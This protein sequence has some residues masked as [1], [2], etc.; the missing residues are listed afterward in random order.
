MLDNAQRLGCA[1]GIN[2]RQPV[3]RLRLIC[4]QCF[5]P[6]FGFLAQR[7]EIGLRSEFGRHGSFLLKRLTSA[8]PGRKKVRLSTEA[9]EWVGSNSLAADRRRPKRTAEDFGAPIRPLSTVHSWRR[10]RCVISADRSPAGPDRPAG[11]EHQ[12]D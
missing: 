2:S 5:E 3:E 8:E 10:C 11:V 7:F 12:Q 6:A 4:A 9:S 1:Y